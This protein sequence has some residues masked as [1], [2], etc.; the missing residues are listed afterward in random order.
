MGDGL[1]SDRARRKEEGIRRKGRQGDWATRRGGEGVG[2]GK[3]GRNKEEGATGR[4]GDW[5][6]R[7]GGEGA[8]GRVDGSWLII[9]NWV[10][11]CI[12][13]KVIILTF[14]GAE[15]TVEGF[16]VKFEQVFIFEFLA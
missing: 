15:F 3:G 11:I 1:K 14:E 9:I 8:R 10:I 4:Q 6:T 7:R 13:F 2:K 12:Y 5:A 16:F